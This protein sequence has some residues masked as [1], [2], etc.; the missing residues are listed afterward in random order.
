MAKSKGRDGIYLRNGHY[1]ISFV[2]FQGRRRQQKTNAQTLTQARSIRAQKLADAEKQRVLGY[3][4]PSQ[5]TF[6]EFQPRYL[7]HQK[8]RLTP[9][10]YAR[11]RGIVE[12]H[13]HSAFAN[14]RLAEIRRADVQRY[15][16]ER[17]GTVGTGS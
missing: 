10:A 2:D 5:D 17:T 16:T 15:I 3:A 12:N 6:A 8:A 14:V 9:L 1:Y 4:P 11:T 13:L 7:Q